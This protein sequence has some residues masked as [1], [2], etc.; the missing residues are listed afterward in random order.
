M[1]ESVFPKKLMLATDGSEHSLDAAKKA[2]KMAKTNAADVV[3]VNV[4]HPSR[5]LVVPPRSTDIGGQ[6]DIETEKEI[7]EKGKEIMNGTK[8]V[9]DDA[10][11]KTKTQF[12]VGNVAKAII[13]EAAKENVDLIVVGAAGHTRNWL[14]GS[15]ADKVATNATCPVLIVR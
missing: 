10:H 8:K 13:N 3:I 5:H 7:K 12:L 2:A 15:V 9:F 14:L 6:I 11:V 1:A 4:L